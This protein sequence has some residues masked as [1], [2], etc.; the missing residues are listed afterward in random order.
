MQIEPYTIQM[1]VIEH[2]SKIMLYRWKY[3]YKYKYNTNRKLYNANKKI[4]QCKWKLKPYNESY[5]IQKEI[6]T[7]QMKLSKIQVEKIEYY[8]VWHAIH[9]RRLHTYLIACFIYIVLRW[10][11]DVQSAGF[12]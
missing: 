3:K 11:F 9:V 4:I 8:K 12:F 6:Y 10:T 7:T 5:S 2:K 1:K